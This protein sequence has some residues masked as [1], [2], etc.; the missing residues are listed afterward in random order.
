[1][2]Y[3]LDRFHARRHVGPWCVA[4]VHTDTAKNEC[5]VDRINT[6]ACEMSF[7]WSAGYK[8]S[9]RKNARWTTNLFIQELLDLHHVDKFWK[10]SLSSVGGST[11]NTSWS[12]S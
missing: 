12:S 7:A 2:G 6:S 10:G 9:F 11:E 5:H 4:N 1:M 3:V 8:H